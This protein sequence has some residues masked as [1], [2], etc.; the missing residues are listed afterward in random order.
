M[1]KKTPGKEK[2]KAPLEGGS[3]TIG[4]HSRRILYL[5]M[6]LIT[7]VF[8]VGGWF[9]YYLREQQMRQRIEDGLSI[10]AQLKV[11]E[12]AHW[13]AERLVDANMLVGS[14]FF[15][16]GVK[17]YVAFPEDSETKDK[18]IGQLGNIAKSYPYQD[19]LL[20]DVNGK[21]LINLN[22]SVHGL[23]NMALAQLAVATG[24]HKAV[25]T[26]FHYPPDSNSPHLDVIAPLFAW[27]Q[28]STR[29]IGAVVFSIDPSQYL[30]PLI[31]SWPIPSQTS[32]TLLVERDGD[33]VLFLNELRHE[34]DTALKLRI[35]L[36]RQEVP[37]IMAILGKEG[38]VEGEDYRGV[39]VLAALKHV[40]DSPWYIVAKIDTSEALSAWRFSAG[41]IAA[42]IAGLLAAALASTGLI[43]QRRQRL[44]YQ[45]MYHAESR[46][47]A[48]RSHV[49][50]MLKYANDIILLFDKEYHIVEVN[51]RA[52]EAYGYSRE[53]M[54]DLPLAALIPPGDLSLY[55]ARLRQIQQ[56][57]R[58]ITE[59]IHQSKNGSTFPVE[60][61]GRIINIEDKQYVQEIIR[62]ISER[63]EA[64]KKLRQTVA[65]LERSNAELER[66]A[67]V[68]SHDL[69]E[70]LRMIS[71]Y[72]QLLEK[73]YKDRLDGDAHDFINFAVDGAKRMQ[74]LINDL[75]AYSRVGTRG[76]PLEPADCE[77]AFGAA[78]S[79]LDV[80]I[81]ENKAKVV[82]DPLPTIMADQVQLVQ[83]FQN[84][85]SNAIKFHSKK[86]PR[87]HVSAKLNEDKWIFVVKD[88]GIGV[89]P[90]YFDR[91]FLIFQR[92]HREE[93][94]GTGTGLAIAKRIVERHGGQIWIESEPGKGSNFYFTLP[95]KGGE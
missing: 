90:Q 13:R 7:V 37:A 30:Y 68:A 20:V 1:A 91:I 69:Q 21:V 94:S 45:A 52:L 67:Y 66:F 36:S 23:S 79:N 88:N 64:E 51:D 82:H 50:Y 22:D 12:I 25:I 60:V 35:P 39:K 93:Y 2:F 85:I 89:E 56:K 8:L 26:D 57:G 86:P 44:A 24:E 9:L 49:E 41:I 16:E 73:R 71:S 6:A 43:W 42:F 61:S 80:A 18:I 92:L 10:I 53:E 87:V 11:D 55:E 46:A 32:E 63:K 95:T 59:A 40:P 54:L 76:K 4:R 29:A 28:D 48:L 62:D 19:I 14:P 65:E 15:M 27:Q 31:Q 84:L 58:I 83:L 77:E 74:Q 78:L 70:P 34:K 17:K 81:K 33:Q 75:L 5:V 3:R 47:Q 38:V 72:T